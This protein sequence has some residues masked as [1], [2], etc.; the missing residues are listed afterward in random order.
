MKYGNLVWWGSTYRSSHSG[1][2]EKRNSKANGHLEEEVVTHGCALVELN[3][4]VCVIVYV[5]RKVLRV[6]AEETVVDVVLEGKN[7]VEW[8]SLLSFH[9]GDPLRTQP[10]ACDCLQGKNLPVNEQKCCTR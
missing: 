1:K 9:V 2:G 6:G 3:E 4:C 8:R 10:S 7:N 5:K